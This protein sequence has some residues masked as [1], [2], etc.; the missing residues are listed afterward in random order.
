MSEASGDMDQAAELPSIMAHV[1]VG[2]NN[3]QKAIL[4][5]DKVLKTIGATRIVEPHEGAVAWGRVYPE[6]WVQKP[7]NG[8]AAETANGSH[9]AFLASSQQMVDDFYAAAMAAG[10]EDDGKPGP[11]IEYSEAYYGCFVRDLDGHKIEAMHWDFSKAP[12]TEA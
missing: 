2:S 1:S 7:F 5:Y 9:F 6:F 4:F 8:K 11:R 12:V 10:A 3:F